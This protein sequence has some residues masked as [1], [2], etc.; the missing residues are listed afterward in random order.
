MK[1]YKELVKFLKKDFPQ[2]YPVSVRRVKMSNEY[3]GDCQLKKG[4]FLIRINKSLSEHVAIDTILHEYAHCI[5]W[6]KCTVDCHCSEW[7]KAYSRLYRAFLKK[8]LD[9]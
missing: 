9:G 3:D 7:G 1:T 5:A 6:K 4:K 8:F 2:K